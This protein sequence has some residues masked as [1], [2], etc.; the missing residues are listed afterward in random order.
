LALRSAIG[1]E[2]WLRAQRRRG[3]LDL[4]PTGNGRSLILNHLASR[5]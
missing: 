4:P 1:I 3:I 5:N 2:H